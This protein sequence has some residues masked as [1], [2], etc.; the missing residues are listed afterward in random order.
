MKK[1]ISLLSAVACALVMSVS[2]LAQSNPAGEWDVTMNTPGGPQNFKAVFK[3]DGEKLTGEIKRGNAPQGL[4]AQGTIKGADIQFTYNVKY[5]DNDLAITM[6]GKL[7]GDSM[8][9]TVSFGGF[10][11]DEWS[12]KRAN[13]SAAASASA[14]TQVAAGGSIDVTGVWDAEVQTDQGSGN[15][16][17]TLKQDGEKLTGKYKGMLGES[18]LTGTVKNGQIEFSYKISGQVEGVVTVTGTTD[19]KT[20]SGKIKLAELGEG[21]ITGKKK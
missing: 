6:T 19:G 15:P 14:A 2:A 9:G 12:A 13:G 4:P 16:T 20:M 8:K 21:K 1:A 18:D 11:E 3:V 10:A 17:F 5:Q 7:D